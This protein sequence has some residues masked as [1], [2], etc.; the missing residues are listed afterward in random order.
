MVTLPLPTVSDCTDGAPST[1]RLPS[2]RLCTFMITTLSVLVIAPLSPSA[3]RDPFQRTVYRPDEYPKPKMSCPTCTLIDFAV[4]PRGAVSPKVQPIELASRSFVERAMAD[5]ST[6]TLC[7]A[8][9][10]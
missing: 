4:A 2:G 1:S 9:R 8:T 7:G 10:R 3:Y 6:K 5:R